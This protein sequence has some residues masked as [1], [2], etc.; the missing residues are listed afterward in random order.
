[1]I[2][3]AILFVVL[4]LVELLYI[5]LARRY[6]IGVEEH[7]GDRRVFTP[8]GGGCIFIIAAIYASLAHPFPGPEFYMALCGGVFLA[9]VSYIDDVVKLSA[10]LRLVIQTLLMAAILYPLPLHGNFDA[11][12]LAL[13]GCVG[14]I[15]A[16]NFMDG[17]NGMLATYSAVVLGSLIL[18][19]GTVPDPAGCTSALP[20]PSSVA[21]ISA[22]LLTAV[23]A[24]ALFNFRPRALVFSGDVGSI[25]LGFFIALGLTSLIVY[26]STVSMA[27]FVVVYLVDTF[28]T[29][30]QRLLNG[31]RV[32]EPHRKH[33]YQL[34]LRTGYSSSTVATTYSAIQLI[35]SAGWFVTPEKWQNFYS[36]TATLV[37]LSVYVWLK[38]NINRRLKHL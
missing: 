2:E 9:I 12:L 14:Y 16:S 1:M 11:Y 5:R 27:I 22:A 29:F 21:A 32:L 33:L 31:E 3:Y 8:V 4:V 30:V 26:S 10:R 24:F 6:G 35:V 25:T 20:P 28:C 37:L 13:I 34:L 7:I 23:G 17:S 19:A 36:L 38:V 18:A 15:N